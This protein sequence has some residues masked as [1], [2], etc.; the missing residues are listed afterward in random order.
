MN[1]NMILIQPLVS[2]DHERNRD[3]AR[4]L[5]SLLAWNGMREDIVTYDEQRGKFFFFGTKPDS[6]WFDVN[7]LT[8][9][10]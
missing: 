2:G 10:V 1:M 6:F 9:S 7:D 3:T 5:S 4:K 8:R